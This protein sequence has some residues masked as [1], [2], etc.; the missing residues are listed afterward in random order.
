MSH[1]AQAPRSPRARLASALLST[2]LSTLLLCALSASAWAQEAPNA[3]PNAQPDEPGAQRMEVVVSVTRGGAAATPVSSAPVILRAARPK[4]PFEPSDPKP[5][6]EWT[7]VSD[8]NGQVVFRDVPADL[9]SRGLRLHAVT[10]HEDVAHKSDAAVPTPG[11]KLKLPIFE[12][13]GDISLLEYQAVRLIVEPSED[14]LVFSL[15]VSLVVR[16]DKALD[17]SML[18]GE[19]FAKGLPIELPLKA[20]GIHS[21]GPGTHA[22]V[23]ST[24][25]WQGVI[26]PAEPVNLQLRYSIPVRDS[27]FVYE[28][29]LDYPAKQVDIV[30]PLQT[31]FRKIPRLNALSLAVLDFDVQARSDVPGIRQDV[32]TLYAVAKRPLKAQD[33]IKMQLVGLPFKRSSGPWAALGLAALGILGVAALARAE[34]A[35]AARAQDPSHRLEKLTRERDAL[36]EELEQLELELDKGLITA[37]DYEIEGM[38]MRERLALI[39]RKLE[40]L[41]QAPAGAA[42]RA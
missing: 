28:Q 27:R 4:G 23:N 6:H 3:Q 17:T 39:L 29:R 31:Q 26:R 8:A 37:R 34:A 7:G 25:Y 40:D 36:F 11:M 2:L 19:R 12:K 33:S 15:T 42:S 30:V 9:A 16:S 5:E 14:Y 24:V 10:L 38:A 22:T 32:E 13:T 21:F 1:L 20:Q 18:S 41:G 35:R